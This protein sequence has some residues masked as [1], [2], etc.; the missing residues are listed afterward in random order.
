MKKNYSG[1]VNSI[2]V[3]ILIITI[4]FALR[5]VQFGKLYQNRF[6]VIE[7][8]LE[9]IEKNM[10]EITTD[11]VWG[12]LKE[13]PKAEKTQVEAYNLIVKDIKTCYLLEKDLGEETS[14]NI[15]ILSYKEK[16]TI[17]NKELKAIFDNDT[18]IKNF[19]KYNTMVF[20]KNKDLNEK[21]QKQ[22]DLI[23]NT[24]LTNSKETD[25]GE[26]LSRETNLVHNIANLS[27]WLKIEYNTYK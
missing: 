10:E 13:I 9:V 2:L 26:A 7:Q 11:A 19:D 18:C 5:P 22:I 20:S 14:D 23:I 12:S 27:G 4:Y 6:E 1:I 21:L 17:S 25:F 15:K 24:D 16:R 3:I 8:T